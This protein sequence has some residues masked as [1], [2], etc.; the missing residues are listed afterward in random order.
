[1]AVNLRIPAMTSS[2]LCFSLLLLALLA[3]TAAAQ[4]AMPSRSVGIVVATSSSPYAGEGERLRA[5]PFIGWEGERVY[6][7]GLDLG[8]RLWQN[9]RLQLEA[10][11]SAR[12]DGFD[13]EDLGRRELATNGVD[14]DL[15]DDRSDGV[16]AMLGLRTRAWPIETGVQL[17]HDISGASGGSELRL[18]AGWPLQRAAWRWTPYLQ[19]RWLSADLAD[20]YHGVLDREAARGVPAWKPGSAWQPELGLNLTY[21]SRLGWF[22]AANLRH[23]RLPGALADSPLVER[24]HESGL[25]VA[26]GRAF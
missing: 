25:I 13:A 7:R 18:R 20:Y 8:L 1:M 2:R 22:V 14:R 17:R 10:A 21:A 5:F 9:D 3:G 16:D 19:L 6:L 26:L 4:P 23:G 15:L 11:L 12:L 24:R